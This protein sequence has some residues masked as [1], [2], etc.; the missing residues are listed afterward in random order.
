MLC[1][2][3]QKKTSR[4]G[5]EGTTRRRSRLS[6]LALPKR[7]HGL[8]R[9]AFVASTKSLH[10]PR[11]Q[12]SGTHGPQV[13]PPL[14]ATSGAQRQHLGAVLTTH[15]GGS[16]REIT[17]VLWWYTPSLSGGPKPNEHMGNSKNCTSGRANFC[18][19]QGRSH[20]LGRLALRGR[21]GR[22]RGGG[23]AGEAPP[24]FLPDRGRDVYTEGGRVYGLQCMLAPPPPSVL[25]A[26]VR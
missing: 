5:P 20:I 22:G 13:G 16:P 18:F 1:K 10:R 15:T 21:G 23:G 19:H 2:G 24:P 25:T 11:P 9:A 3:T 17:R 12:C 26:E 4:A 7:S 14:S 6:A 8:H